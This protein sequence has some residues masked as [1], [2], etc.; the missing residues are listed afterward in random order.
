MPYQHAESEATLLRYWSPIVVPGIAQTSRYM[1]SLF[2]D[3]G[4]LPDR[5]SELVTARLQRQSVIGHVHITMIIGH[6]VLYRLVESPEVMAEQCAHLADVAQRANMSA[7][8]CSP[9]AR[10]VCMGV[11]GSLDIATRG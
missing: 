8:P 10:T 11:W 6:P 4:H 5:I 1:R 2:E 9:K 3:E 7:A